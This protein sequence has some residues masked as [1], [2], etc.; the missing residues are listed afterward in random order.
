MESLQNIILKN[1]NAEAHIDL[2]NG[3]KLKL[4]K[5]TDAKTNT[6][7]SIIQDETSNEDFLGGGSFIMYPWVGRLQSKE[8]IINS[9]EITLTPVFQDHKGAPI[10]GLIPTSPRRILERTEYSVTL[11]SDIPNADLR[12]HFP[13]VKEYFLLEN[14]K[15]TIITEFNNTSED[16]QLFAYGYHPYF[17]L[18]GKSI[19]E[20]CIDMNM[21]YNIPL[22]FATLL[23]DT[24]ENGK[25][26]RQDFKTVLKL[27]T[28]IGDKHIDHLFFYDNAEVTGA[29]ENAFVRIFDPESRI[30]VEVKSLQKEEEGFSS[31]PLNFF[32]I[33]T[34]NSRKFVAIEPMTSPGNAFFIDYPNLL[35]HL[36]KQE[37]AKGQFEI[38]LFNL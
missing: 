8:I 12:D 18:D 36:K 34:P 2:F 16:T 9:K 22:N 7:H 29:N 17:G 20:L 4:L 23:A 1:K 27:N 32:Q 26:K 13:Q 33:Y 11:I 24:D 35:C 6:S 21:N 19:N 37:K 10:H 3:G 5:L 31:I 30:G 38:S 25:L 15:L 28:P 14:S